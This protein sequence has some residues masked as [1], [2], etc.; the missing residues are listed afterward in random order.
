MAH[1]PG[2][3]VEDV[4]WQDTIVTFPANSGIPPLY[5]VFAKT[6]VSPPYPRHSY[7]S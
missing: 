4:T 1:Y 3:D 2:R 7:L 5:L 6:A